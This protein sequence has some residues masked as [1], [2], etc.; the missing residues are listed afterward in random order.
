MG[1][2]FQTAFVTLGAASSTSCHEGFLTRKPKLRLTLPFKSSINP[3]V[4]G[5]YTL[6]HLPG[7]YV[8]SVDDF[9]FYENSVWWKRGWVLQERGLSKRMLVFGDHMVHFL[10]SEQNASENG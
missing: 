2:L 8:S 6:T 4:S 10:C 5:T 1:L 7:S 9:A 3:S